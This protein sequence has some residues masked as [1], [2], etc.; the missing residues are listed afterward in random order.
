MYGWNH[1]IPMPNICGIAYKSQSQ[2]PFTLHSATSPQ[3]GQDLLQS[4][5]I[6]EAEGPDP[7]SESPY[8]IISTNIIHYS[9]LGKVLLTGNFN[10]H[11]Q[12]CQCEL[13]NFEDP[14]VLKAPDIEDTRTTPASD[15]SGLDYTGFGQ[16]L[17]SWERDITSF[18]VTGWHNGYP[19]QMLPVS[20]R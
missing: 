20:G 3:R 13:Y 14:M 8:S 10:A 19:R 16:H 17:W 9:T 2:G 6:D 1:E 11:T 12:I 4:I 7:P 18:F 5:W 15:D